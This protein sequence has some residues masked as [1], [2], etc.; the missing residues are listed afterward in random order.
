MAVQHR[1]YSKL[2]QAGYDS[3]LLLLINRSK[4]R[5]FLEVARRTTMCVDKRY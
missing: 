4:H 2:W 3:Q 5:L 1:I